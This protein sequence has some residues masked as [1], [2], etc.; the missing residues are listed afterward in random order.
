METLKNKIFLECMWPETWIL[1]LALNNIYFLQGLGERL[2]NNEPPTILSNK[3]SGISFNITKATHFSLLPALAHRQLYA[4]WHSI[5]QA[6][7]TST[8]PT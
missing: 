3:H 7:H 6:R 4:R 2:R 5:T 1:F 8:P